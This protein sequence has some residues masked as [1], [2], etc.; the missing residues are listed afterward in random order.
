M[1]YNQWQYVYSNPINLVDPSGFEGVPPGV[2]N[3]LEKLRTQA[4]NCYNDNN[5]LCVWEAYFELAAF[6]PAFGYKYSS[7]HLFNFL[8]K[9]GDI[10]YV[11]FGG[12][13]KKPSLWVFSDSHVRKPLRQETKEMWTR[14][15]LDVL[16]GKSKGH[17]KTDMSEVGYPGQR[18]DLW[19]ALGNFYVY[20]EADYEVSGCY[21]VLVKPTYYFYDNYDW[22]PNLGAGGGVGGLGGFKDE[23]AKSLVPTYAK[24]YEI[25]G[26][27]IGPNKLY[28]FSSK[29][30]DWSVN[31]NT[32]STWEY[33]EP[34]EKNRDIFHF[35]D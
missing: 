1:S 32:Y 18:T 20:I 24:E 22:H 6:A 16:S 21:D 30:L 31:K 35:D 12:R 7:D 5:S 10:E 14:I 8:F 23:W 26:S 2:E 27:W 28:H 19:Y 29:W 25:T 3:Y 13:G 4:E 34:F 11:S 33:Y 9:G 15:H 17:V